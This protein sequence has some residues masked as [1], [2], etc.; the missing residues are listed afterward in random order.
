MACRQVTLNTVGASISTMKPKSREKKNR[1]PKNNTSCTQPFNNRLV[2]SRSI[3]ENPSSSRQR[4]E[5]RPPQRSHEQFHARRERTNEHECNSQAAGNPDAPR[6]VENQE[7]R[8]K[9]A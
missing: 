8:P 1:A 2:S 3:E 5:I 6:A 4:P 9:S 7:L